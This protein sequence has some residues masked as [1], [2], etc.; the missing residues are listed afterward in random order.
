MLSISRLA[1]I[2]KS[3][4]TTFDDTN[5]MATERCEHC[6]TTLGNDLTLLPVFT[7]RY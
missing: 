6:V 2:E 7:S 4:I 5:T 1:E 3:D